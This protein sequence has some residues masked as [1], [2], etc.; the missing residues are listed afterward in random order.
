MY[1]I[2]ITLLHIKKNYS[3]LMIFG[4]CL[5]NFSWPWSFTPCWIA[6]APSNLHRLS[7]S[8]SKALDCLSSLFSARRC[9]HLAQSG[10]LCPLG[11]LFDVELCRGFVLGLFIP[12]V[13]LSS[14]W[15]IGLTS[16]TSISVVKSIPLSSRSE[17]KEHK[18]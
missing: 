4:N 9:W 10:S 11:H 13:G 2:Q 17:E 15:G 6:F 1:L 3:Y 8:V 16:S 5:G 14:V 7:C 18:N 12:T